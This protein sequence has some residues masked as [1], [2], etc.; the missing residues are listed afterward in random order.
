MSFIKI[1]PAR[2]AATTSLN[3]SDL[4]ALQTAQAAEIDRRVAEQLAALRA[5]T[6]AKAKDEAEAEARAV[7]NTQTAQLTQTM[8]ALNQAITQLA[9]PL[10]EKEQELADLVLDMA[11]QLARH[12]AGGETGHARED[13]F[14]LV[15]GLLNEA[16]MER[17]PGQKLLLSLHPADLETLHAQAL[18]CEAEIQ[19]D[20]SITPGGAVI[21][22]LGQSQDPL[23]KS[24]WDA[25]LESRLAATRAA[26]AMPGKEG[27][28]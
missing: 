20:G 9:T 16:G 13:L 5:E 19:P 24:V 8:T 4:E 25:R 10:A 1:A 14:T 2:Q 21:E 18:D 26:L 17:Q 6:L 28:E 15:L 11:F 23:D 7:L 22:L 12:I 3:V 27:G